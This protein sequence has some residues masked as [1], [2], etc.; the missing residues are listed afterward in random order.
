MTTKA[1]ATM[2]AAVSAALVLVLGTGAGLAQGVPAETPPP[3]YT[4]D[5]YVD[6]AGCIFVRAGVGGNVTWVP[7]VGRD[8][9]QLCG[10]RPTL[11]GATTTLAA[12]P[13]ENVTI[14]G[15][16]PA[17]SQATASATTT[18]A[19]TTARTTAVRPAAAATATATATT[20]TRPPAA[21][22]TA[23]QPV[24]RPG[25][26]A[27]CPGMTG[28]TGQYLFGRCGPQAVHPGDAARGIVRPGPS[29]NGASL[30]RPVVPEG[31]RPAFDDGRLNPLRGPRTAAGDAQMA[32]VWTDQLPRRLVSDVAPGS[33]SRGAPQPV[34]RARAPLPQALA[35]DAAAAR[36][37]IPANHRNILA[38]TY[39]DRAAADRALVQLSAAGQPTR[40]GVIARE[41]GQ[42][43]AVVAGPYPSIEALVAGYRAT[44]SAGFAG[45][46]TRR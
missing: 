41:T 26:V 31:F 22:P 4:A 11:G 18:T 36:V 2:R 44:R 8:R 3:S 20:I 13:D 28:L 7:R 30:G 24:T 10:F 14:I 17:A 45:A 5:Q 34:T 25:G 32:Q 39:A 46:V 42:V 9:Q 29:M 37:E 16:P 27:R 21:A 1:N 19:T 12:A 6:S 43:Y 23:P 15:A 33:A 35:S 38:G 40:L